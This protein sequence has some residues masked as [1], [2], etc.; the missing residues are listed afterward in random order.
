ML[1]LFWGLGGMALVLADTLANLM[2]AAIAGI[3]IG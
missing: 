2:S 3:L 1:D